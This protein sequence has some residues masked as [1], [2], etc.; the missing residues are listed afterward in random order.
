[1]RGVVCRHCTE[2]AAN[3]LTQALMDPNAGLIA[4]NRKMAE[5]LLDA[6]DVALTMEPVKETDRDEK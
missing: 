5:V 6:C 3:I 1:M 4:V 2:E